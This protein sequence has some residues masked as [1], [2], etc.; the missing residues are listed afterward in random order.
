M[1]KII[2][3][4]S[5]FYGKSSIYSSDNGKH[6]LWIYD[7]SDHMVSIRRDITAEDVP[8]AAVYNKQ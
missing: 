4:I 7:Q 2:L 5:G 8:K 1:E 3:R 6:T